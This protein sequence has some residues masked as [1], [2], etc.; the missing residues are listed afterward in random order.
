MDTDPIQFLPVHLREAAS[1][2]PKGQ[3]HTVLEL[4]DAGEG[5]N[6]GLLSIASTCYWMGVSQ[7]GE[8]DGRIYSLG[9]AM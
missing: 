5:H 9:D 3:Q 4:P 2:L 6:S 1:K 7:E 8:R